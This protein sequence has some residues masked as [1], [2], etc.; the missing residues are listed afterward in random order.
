LVDNQDRFNRTLRVLQLNRALPADG[1]ESR[2]RRPTS[3]RLN[4]RWTT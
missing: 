4:P 2:P 1:E 3:L